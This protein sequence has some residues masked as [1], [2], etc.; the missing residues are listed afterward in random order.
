MKYKGYSNGK[1][2]DVAEIDNQDNKIGLVQ[3]DKYRSPVWCTFERI[4]IVPTKKGAKNE[5]S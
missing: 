4:E 1:V 5:N 3:L 2:Y